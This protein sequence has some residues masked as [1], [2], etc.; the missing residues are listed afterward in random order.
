MKKENCS[1]LQI[2]EHERH[3]S[4]MKFTYTIIVWLNSCEKKCNMTKIDL[5][6]ANW[7]GWL[8]TLF[9]CLNFLNMN[10][11]TLALRN[12]VEVCMVL[13]SICFSYGMGVVTD[14]MTSNL[15]PFKS[16]AWRNKPLEDSFRLHK[17]PSLQSMKGSSD[18]QQLSVNT[19]HERCQCPSGKDP[20]LVRSTRGI[21]TNTCGSVSM[22]PQRNWKNHCALMYCMQICG[23]DCE[24]GTSSTSM[25]IEHEIC[26]W[27]VLHDWFVWWDCLVSMMD[28]LWNSF[29]TFCDNFTSSL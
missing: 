19:W 22:T 29:V 11:Q 5:L 3:S 28:V 10:C 17:S 13:V 15:I 25:F 4:N 20:L 1:C 6:Y 24:H 23:S 9:T 27:H 2:V 12:F 14:W 21:D 7:W 18:L 8:W 16:H 26:V